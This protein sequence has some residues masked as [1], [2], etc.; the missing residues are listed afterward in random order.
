MQDRQIIILF[1]ASVAM[2]ALVA[3]LLMAPL[4]RP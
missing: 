3:I 4:A 1:I 2:F